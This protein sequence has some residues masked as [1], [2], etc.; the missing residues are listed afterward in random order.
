MRLHEALLLFGA[1]A[2]NESKP[3]PNAVISD[4]ASP[5]LLEWMNR[6]WGKNVG[7]GTARFLFAPVDS[8]AFFAR[9]GWREVRFRSGLEEARRLGRE[10]RG[11]WLWRLLGRF[12]SPARREEFRC[13]SGTILLER[14]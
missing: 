12:A 3:A 6:S 13:M 11:A 7:V 4:I 8:V 1:A 5:R 2:C 9:L 14:V 10:M